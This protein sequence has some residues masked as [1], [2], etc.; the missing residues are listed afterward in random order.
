MGWVHRVNSLPESA[1]HELLDHIDSLTRESDTIS[2]IDALYRGIGEIVPSDRGAALI[3]M[4]DGKPYCVRGPEYFTPHAEAFN[5]HFRFVAP[6]W[7]VEPGGVLGPVTWDSFGDIEYN[8]DFNH[9]L[10]VDSS[11]GISFFDPLSGSR[12][13]LA[14]HRSE[15]DCCFS[16]RERL[17]VGALSSIFSPVHS[18]WCAA[19]CHRDEVSLEGIG[20]STCGCLTPRETEIASL[21]CKRLTLREIAGRLHLSPRT[22]ESHTLHIYW[23]LGVRSR[24][25]LLRRLLIRPTTEQAARASLK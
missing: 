1:W 6:S 11:I 14:V 23:K 8:V 19:A 5:N 3:E 9:P 10:H 15:E 21:L 13:V 7:P 20:R 4:R 16:E 2:L 22:V 12:Y 17:I 18:L 25:D 24:R